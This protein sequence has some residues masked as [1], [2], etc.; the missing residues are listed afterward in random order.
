MIRIS[1][2]ILLFCTFYS[3]KNNVSNEH[4]DASISDT[5]TYYNNILIS[6]PNEDSILYRKGIYL[7]QHNSL[8]SGLISLELAI[9]INKKTPSYFYSLSDA[10]LL[11][12]ES[13]KAESILDTLN[14]YFPDHLP[15]LLKNAR[16]KLILKKYSDALT[17]IDYVFLLDPNNVEANYLAG[18]IFYEQGDTGRAV[19]CYQKSVDLNPEYLE[20]WIQLGDIM[21]ALRN[22]IAIKYYDNA[23][24]LDSSN[25][26]TLHNR[27]YSIQLF[28]KKSEAIQAYKKNILQRPDFELSFYNLGIIYEEMDSFALAVDNLNHA[29]LLNPKEPSSYY[30]RGLCKNK[31]GQN[32][33]SKS[34]LKQAIKLFPDYQKAILL[35][36]KIK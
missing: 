29:I 6:H 13:K 8:D 22:P 36:N 24:R 17:I 35:L 7:I 19:K 33:E 16:L 3:C 10:Y 32:E 5:L 21:T 18:H 12:L 30:H 31:L 1:Y 34:D 11:A 4:K 9:K 25:I 28:G 20:G 26:E 23:I 2:F 14:L 27:A 15:S